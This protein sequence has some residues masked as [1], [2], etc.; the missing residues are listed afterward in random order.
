MDT[1]KKLMVL[2]YDGIELKTAGEIFLWLLTI[3]HDN[4]DNKTLLIYSRLL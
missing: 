3:R 1:S 4:C 2:N